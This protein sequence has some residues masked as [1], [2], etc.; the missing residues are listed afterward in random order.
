MRIRTTQYPDLFGE[1]KEKEL[2]DEKSGKKYRI[3]TTIWPD[4]L[5][6]GKEREIVEVDDSPL[7]PEDEHNTSL[8]MGY[9]GAFLMGLVILFLSESH[10]FEWPWW[11]AVGLT[12][13]ILIRTILK[14][15][16][17]FIVMVLY[18]GIL[19]GFLGSVVALIIYCTT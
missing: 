4:L 17:K 18:I 6:E 16:G 2:V 9:G 14:D 7:T 15:V 19:V 11:L 1:G 8:Y 13:F 12:A 10:L 5:G 3:R